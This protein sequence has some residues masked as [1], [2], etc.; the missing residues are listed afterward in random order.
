MENP[1]TPAELIERIR[2][3]LVCDRCQKYVGSLDAR[4]YLPPAYPVAIDGAEDEVAALIGYEWHMLG[5]LVHA[6]FTIRHPQLEGRCVSIREWA[7]SEETGDE[8]EVG[9][10]EQG[11]GRDGRSTRGCAKPLPRPRRGHEGAG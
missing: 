8:D 5:R 10:R 9:N 2:E 1:S 11:T 7:A 6:G 3:G 4:R